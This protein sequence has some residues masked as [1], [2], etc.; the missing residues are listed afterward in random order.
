MGTGGDQRRRRLW[1]LIR[2][3]NEKGKEKNFHNKQKKEI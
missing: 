1:I 2:P 3:Q